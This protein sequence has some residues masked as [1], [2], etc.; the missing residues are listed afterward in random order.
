MIVL[1]LTGSIGMGKSTTA[2]F[3]RDAGIAVH[4]ADATVHAL[5]QNEAVPLLAEHFPEAVHEGRVDRARLSALVMGKPEALAK[6]EALIHPL[7]RNHE[8]KFLENSRKTQSPIAVLDIPLLFETGGDQRCD[9]IVVTT[10]P[11][12]V[13]R[14]RVLARSDMTEN[15]LAR[16]LAKQMPDGE[17][18]RRAHFVIDTSLG[19]TSAQRHVHHIIAVFAGRG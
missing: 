19:L 12:A 4:D 18:R 16:I 9:V 11:V 17:K 14:A 7:V 10:A 1:G 2:G 5:Y 6:L 13:Q 3:F 15:K 8:Q